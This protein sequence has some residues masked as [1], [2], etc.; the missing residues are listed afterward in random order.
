LIWQQNHSAIQVEKCSLWLQCYW[1]PQSMHSRLVSCQVWFQLLCPAELDLFD[2]VDLSVA[3]FEQQRWQLPHQS[4]WEHLQQ[5]Q[6]LQSHTRA[7][8]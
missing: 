8:Q 5:P 7:S 4:Q 6:R 3:L 2:L 1:I